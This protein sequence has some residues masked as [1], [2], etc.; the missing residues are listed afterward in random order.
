MSTILDHF[1]AVLIAVLLGFGTLGLTA[2]E[3]D[4]AFEEAGE[5]VDQAGEE[6]GD[7]FEEA[8]EEVE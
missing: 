3:E 4:G 8:E 2:C 5:E 1:K 7:Q 6:M